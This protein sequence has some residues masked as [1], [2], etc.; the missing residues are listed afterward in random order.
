MTT[1]PSSRRAIGALI[2][3][4]LLTAMLLLPSPATALT[5]DPPLSLSEEHEIDVKTVDP[6]IVGT[7]PASPNVF[8]M[9]PARCGTGG[10]HS[11]EC[12]RIDVNIQASTYQEF[13]ADK[14]KNYLLILSL[15]WPNERLPE[16][17]TTNDLD[18]YFWYRTIRKNKADGVETVTWQEITH[19]ASANPT[20]LIR[21]FNLPGPGTWTLFN[22]NS[23]TGEEDAAF[24]TT[25]FGGTYY[26]TIVN[27]SGVNQKYELTAKYV[28][29]Q[30][31]ERPPAGAFVFN[32]RRPP[33][34]RGGSDNTARPGGA[35]GFPVGSDE[36][37]L[38]PSPLERPGEDGPLT[39]IQLPLL[40]AESR[41]NRASSTPLIGAIV[42]AAVLLGTFLVVWITFKRRRALAEA[43]QNI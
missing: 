10:T 14:G 19:S 1:R 13:A 4:L 34:T 9:H 30:L 15:K 20:E 33:T 24:D 16:A 28:P 37:S 25:Y 31:G 2:S 17:T 43:E 6:G 12:D 22:Y 35:P 29:V 11:A 41:T 42:L 18:M 40:A 32:P 5:R 36:S 26:V 39:K 23:S 27:F 21:L 8:L 3:V 38:Q 7:D